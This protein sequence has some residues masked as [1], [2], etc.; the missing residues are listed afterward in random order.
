MTHDAACFYSPSRPGH[1]YLSQTSFRTG[2]R[3][4]ARS[5][6]CLKITATH[7]LTIEV[8]ALHK[9]GL[10][11]VVDV[12]YNHTLASGPDGALSVLDKC[13]PG[14]YYRRSEPG[15]LAPL[16]FVSWC[17][18]G[19]SGRQVKVMQLPRQFASLFESF[20]SSVK[21]RG[22]LEATEFGAKLHLGRCPRTQ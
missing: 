18:E 12:V 8:A 1:K 11:V 5:R 15:L 21:G 16:R 19:D 22:W 6:Q 17:A 3:R 10:R 14:Y 20:A 13:A 7:P 4:A 9:K 2:G